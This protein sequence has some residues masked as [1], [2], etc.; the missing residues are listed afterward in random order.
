MESPYFNL[1][2]G[3]FTKLH[4]DNIEENFP[5][6]LLNKLLGMKIDNIFVFKIS[7]TNRRSIMSLLLS[8][9]SYH[10]WYSIKKL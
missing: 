10:E 2:D 9:M 8:Y 5:Y 1:S 6:E 4:D 7:S 3:K